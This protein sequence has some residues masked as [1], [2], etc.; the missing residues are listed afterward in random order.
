MFIEAPLFMDPLM[1]PWEK[2]I[3]EASGGKIEISSKMGG[4]EYN[5]RFRLKKLPGAPGELPL[6]SPDQVRHAYR[7]E[8]L[9]RTRHAWSITFL[10]S[11]LGFHPPKGER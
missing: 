5:T 1:A 3:V 11:K 10:L 8:R 7:D 4:H 6:L 9:A 2:Q